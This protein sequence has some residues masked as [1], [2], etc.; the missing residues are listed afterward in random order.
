MPDRYVQFPIET[1]PTALSDEAFAY[2]QNAIPGWEPNAGNLETWLIE[3][4]ARMVAEARD[5]A[6]DVPAAI[7]RYFGSAM[8]GLPP[9]D[10]SPANGETTWTLVDDS[11]HTIPA[12]TL[13]GL[14]SL[15]GELLA[16]RTIEDVVVP[17]GE[18]V[19]E[20]VLIIAEEAGEAGSGLE[21]PPELIDSLAF[22]EEIELVEATS[23]GQDAE[24]DESYLNR[25]AREGELL[26]PR[27]IL[28][29]D[30]ATLAMR[31]AGVGRATA[32]DGYDPLTDTDD[33]ERMVAVAVVDDQGQPVSGGTKAEVEALLED[34]R[35]VNFVVH[36]V[37]PT[38]T[39]VD[40]T[41]TA[42]AYEGYDVLDVQE[43]AIAAVEAYLNPGRWGRPPFSDPTIP[44]WVD[45][46]LVRYLDLAAEIDR[47]EGI[48]YVASLTINGGTS[49]VALAGAIGLPTAGTITGTVS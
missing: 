24:S 31:V 47:V 34:M 20:G 21:G 46:P 17:P 23:G 26:T 14:R 12:G 49:N 10:A 28:P 3:A 43:R 39:E 25:L 7:F 45:E 29:R 37:D 33:N 18:T 40:V 2:L 13:V 15:A 22:V 41:F 42:T 4:C 8:I 9:K 44:L 30:F 36:V 11:G 27:P 32:R 1:D 16:F 48:R 19:A 35:E 38:Y 5:V 6:S